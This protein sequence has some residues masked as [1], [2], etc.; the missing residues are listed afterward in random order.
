M[1]LGVKCLRRLNRVSSIHT[2]RIS[3]TIDSLRAREFT[4]CCGAATTD[5]RKMPASGA[6]SV[7]EDDFMARL[8]GS[9]V[10]K[11]SEKLFSE[12]RPNIT[13]HES[14]RPGTS[15]DDDFARVKFDHVS[16]WED[17][18]T[19]VIDD[20]FRDQALD[21]GLEWTCGDQG[22][23]RDANS[24]LHKVTDEK[25]VDEIVSKCLTEPLVKS[26]GFCGNNIRQQLGL[27]PLQPRMTREGAPI[28]VNNKGFPKKMDWPIYYED[29]KTVTK[30][31]KKMPRTKIV[32][33]KTILV[34][35]DAKRN[36]VFQP[37][38]LSNKDSFDGSD[39]YITLGQLG[40]YAFWGNTRYAFVITSRTLTVLR[41]YLISQDQGEI[42][43]GVEWNTVSWKSPGEGQMSVV[44]KAIWAL[45]LLSMDD[46][47]RAIVQ[48]HEIQPLHAWWQTAS[49]AA[50]EPAAESDTLLRASGS[51]CL[52]VDSKRGPISDVIILHKTMNSGVN[53]QRTK[54]TISE[55]SSVSRVSSATSSPTS[56]IIR[57]QWHLDEAV[58]LSNG[59][60]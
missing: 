48:Q 53:Q 5:Y 57:L 1:I 47:N 14:D 25:D 45:T 7:G 8:L 23:L 54:N 9:P 26:I 30:L 52:A 2:K 33:T 34:A 17:F 44:C 56:A 36:H 3:I 19:D 15:W 37:E 59:N 6:T 21:R 55:I 24:K 13:I 16:K 40:M 28:K 42:Q 43:L 51:G 22:V 11:S 49:R 41:Y 31:F 29:T 35:G 38:W 39:A 58:R 27:A 46:N 4:C 32:N 20:L 12:I 50:N 60:T 10:R 18:S